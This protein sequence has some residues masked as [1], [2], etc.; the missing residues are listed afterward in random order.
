MSKLSKF[1]WGLALSGIA[2]LLA[3]LTGAWMGNSEDAIREGWT[4]AAQPALATLWG[5]DPAK[6][7]GI[8]DKSWTCLMRAHLHWA[9]LGA[10][11]LAMSVILSGIKA[12]PTWY[13]QIGSLFM[14]IGA[15]SYPISWLMVASNLGTLGGPAAKASGHIYAVIGVGTV[16][17]GTAMFLVALIY[18]AMKNNEASEGSYKATAK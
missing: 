11:T 8:I 9:G 15:I 2:V 1:Q 17:V 16:V 4:A 3:F 5:N 10:A 14:G 12:V 13:K 7:A 18:Q 6:L